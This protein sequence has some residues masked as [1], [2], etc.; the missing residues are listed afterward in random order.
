MR[1]FSTGDETKQS[2]TGKDKDGKIMLE[3]NGAD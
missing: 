3:Q 2:F 1:A